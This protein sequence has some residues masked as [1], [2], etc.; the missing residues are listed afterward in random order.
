MALVELVLPAMPAHV[1]TARL[2]GVAAARR[3][4][5]DDEFVDEL[6]LALGEACGRAVLLHGRFAPD[7]PVEIALRDDPAGLTVTVRDRGPVLGSGESATGGA[8]DAGT[9]LTGDVD[10]DEPSALALSSEVALAVVRSLVDEVSVD[11]AS[12]GTTVTMRW[13]LPP[14]LVGIGATSLATERGDG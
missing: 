7:T 12:D 11:S 10:D 2:V 8:S 9:L 13:P 14:R 5:L 3:A 6:R 4:G 1:R